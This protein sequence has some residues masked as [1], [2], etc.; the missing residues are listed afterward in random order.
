MI[1]HL[2]TN[3]LSF[4]HFANIDRYYTSLTF[5]NYFITTNAN[6]SVCLF[7]PTACTL[8]IITY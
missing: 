3:N 4:E 6:Q 2:H 7:I 5:M 8:P 1:V